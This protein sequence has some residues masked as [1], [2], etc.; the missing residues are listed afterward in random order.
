[1]TLT[2]SKLLKKTGP[3][4]SLAPSR[5]SFR[6][7]LEK[8]ARVAVK[9]G[10]YAPYSLSGREPLAFI[11]EVIDKIIANCVHGETVA[12]DGIT[13]LPGQLKGATV[14]VGGG[15]Q[16]GKT[17][18]E[19][20]LMGYVTT[21]EFLS[22]CYFTPDLDLLEKIVDTK[23]RPDV[24]DQVPWIAETIQLGAEVSAS[25]KSVD[26]KNSFQVSAKDRK[27]FGFFWGLRKIPTSISIDIAIVDEVDDV[28]PGKLGFINSRM[29]NSDL[30]LTFKIGTMRL[31]GA[32][33]NAAFESGTCY[34][35]M[36]VCE[37]CQADW[38]LEEEWPGNTRSASSFQTRCHDD[39][40]LTAESGFDSFKF[41]YCACPDCG[42][43][44]DAAAGRYVA[45][46]PDAAK[47][48]NFSFRVSQMACAG[49][50]WA[51]H[52]RDWFKALADPTN[53]EAGITAFDCDHR[54]IPNAGAAQPLTASVIERARISDYPMSLSKPT[55]PVVAGMDLG[56]RCWFWADGIVSPLESRLLWAEMIASGKVMS[57]LPVLMDL[58]GIQCVFLDAG[59]EPDL[60][61]RVCLAL[62]GLEAFEPPV[63][64]QNDL[65]KS[66]LYNIG[67]FGCSWDGQRGQWRGIRAAAVAFVSRGAKGVEQ[68][69]GFTVDGKIYPLINC[70]RAETIESAVNDFLTPEEGVTEL[71]DGH[72]RYQPRARLPKTYPGFGATQSIIDKHLKNLRRDPETNDWIDKVENHFGLAKSYA[73]LAASVVVSGA[74]V[75]TSFRFESG[76]KDNARQYT[77]DSDSTPRRS[78]VRGSRRGEIL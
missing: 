56:P 10:Y 2:V 45:R 17:V 31:Q 68:T 54:A 52:V 40:K 1:M 14:T 46:N 64:N 30:A 39:P 72:V 11:I 7:F 5:K 27:A 58:L 9:K 21:I 36:N 78:V 28:K 53:A 33:Q 74:K 3:A 48:L 69:V 57:R 43:A 13:Y 29:T 63:I 51:N 4:K 67:S 71:V 55:M 38:C 25:K 70:N 37:G 49:I 62:N 35:W 65:R 76:P 16:F 50:P 22:V 77:I 66:M 6:E 59:G 15:A 61:K 34:V 19:L 23:F 18:L 8:D 75:D 73:R 60:T 42:R 24:L 44:L 32:G 47:D 26:K 41:Y 20:N 12:I